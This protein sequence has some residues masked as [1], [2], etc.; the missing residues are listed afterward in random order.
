MLVDLCYVIAA[1]PRERCTYTGIRKISHGIGH[2]LTEL[3]QVDL[4]FL[5]YRGGKTAQLM[6]NYFNEAE[7]EAARVKLKARRDSEHSSIALNTLGQAKDARSQGNCIRSVIITQTRKWTEVDVIY[8]STE[9]IQKNAADFDLLPRILDRLELAHTPRIYRLYF[10]N[11]F[12]TALFAP[13]LFQKT[14]PI[15]FY[16]HLKKHD[17]KYYRTFLN[18]SAKFFEPTCRYQYKHRQK[19]WA[20]A[21]EKL[22][23]KALIQYCKENGA[24]FEPGDLL[25][26]DE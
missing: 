8:R 9:I 1:T 23:C 16:E 2:T 4:T 7:V 20:I 12:L 21:Q 6:R 18:A 24:S 3:P 25:E 14:D 10:A 26:D 22:D 17:P 5:G 13:L 19:M 15:K 11:I